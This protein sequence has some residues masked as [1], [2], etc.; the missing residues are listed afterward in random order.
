[1]QVLLIIIHQ[2]SPP[3]HP[4][5]CRQDGAAEVP[6]LVR[7]REAVFP[8]IIP[9]IDVGH[10]EALGHVITVADQA[11]DE[12]RQRRRD[13]DSHRLRYRSPNRNFVFCQDSHRL[14]FFYFV[15][16]A[17]QAVHETS[18]GTVNDAFLAVAGNQS[19]NTRIGNSRSL[20]EDASQLMAPFRFNDGIDID[21]SREPRA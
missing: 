11:P 18:L 7:N 2:T 4:E 12:P 14:S 5:Q 8:F 3:A 10:L 1:M 21:T 16:D 15:A 20:P 6:G 13:S 9:R 19:G 17:D